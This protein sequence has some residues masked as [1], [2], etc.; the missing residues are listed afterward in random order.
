MSIDLLELFT[1][2]LW[3]PRFIECCKSFFLVRLCS[4]NVKELFYIIWVGEKRAV[5]YHEGVEKEQKEKG[6]DM[7]T[8]GLFFSSGLSGTWLLWQVPWSHKSVGSHRMQL[9]FWT[10]SSLELWRTVDKFCILGILGEPTYAKTLDFR[11]PKTL[12]WAK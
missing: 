12:R 10:I 6:K 1:G 7:S 4:G 3:L 9:L 11:E 5:E 2:L 8:S